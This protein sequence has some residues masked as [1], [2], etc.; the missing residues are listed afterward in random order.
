[1]SFEQRLSN[2]LD[3]RKN[4]QAQARAAVAGQDMPATGNRLANFLPFPPGTDPSIN[5]NRYGWVQRGVYR[6]PVIGGLFNNNSPL[7]IVSAKPQPDGGRGSVGPGVR[8]TNAAESGRAIARGTASPDLSRWNGAKL[9][10][11]QARVK[12]RGILRGS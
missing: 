3:R 12:V 5:G 7:P 1:M 4:A 11:Q 2:L 9:A 8:V 6:I 10:V